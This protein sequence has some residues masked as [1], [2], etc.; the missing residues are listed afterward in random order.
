MKDPFTAV[1]VSIQNSILIRQI[2]FIRNSIFIQNLIFIRQDLIFIQNSM[3]ESVINDTEW[4]YIS[5][6]NIVINDIKLEECNLCKF[7]FLK[8]V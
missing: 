1:Q 8:Y 7:F 3:Q 5:S 6:F 2:T 4:G